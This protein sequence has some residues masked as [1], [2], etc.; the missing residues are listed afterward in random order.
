MNRVS[1]VFVEPFIGLKIQPNR[2][3]S[4]EVG[5]Y[6]YTTIFT[7]VFLIRTTV[8]CSL[9]LL[10]GDYPGFASRGNQRWLQRP[11]NGNN[12]RGLLGARVRPVR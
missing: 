2:D 4:I 6:V 12:A 9:S 7:L 10:L 5:L 8:F 1:P 3:G 11:M